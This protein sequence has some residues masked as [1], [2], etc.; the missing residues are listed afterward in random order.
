MC[1]D[2][3]AQPLLEWTWEIVNSQVSVVCDS[4][5]MF[6]ESSV[7]QI[8]IICYNYGDTIEKESTL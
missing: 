6:P 2:E 4:A 5:H 1:N 3:V 8:Q 7:T